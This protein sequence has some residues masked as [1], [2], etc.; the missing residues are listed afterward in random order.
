VISPRRDDGITLI[1]L[2]VSMMLLSVV[3]AVVVTAV[4]SASRSLRRNENEA[5]GLSD[6]R[7]VTERLGRDIEQARGVSAPGTLAPGETRAQACSNRLTLWIDYNSD[8]IQTVD[9]TVT[10]V[11]QGGSNGHFDVHRIVG[12]LAAPSSNVIEG[13]TLVSNVA[14]SYTPYDNA[15]DKCPVLPSS[16]NVPAP[17]STVSTSIKYNARAASGG[18]DK[19]IDF[20]NRLRNVL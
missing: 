18:S 14:F 10:W 6:V 4:V 8:Y 2:L 13:R 9:E 1:E 15:T 19:T 3:S 5:Q 12:S 11:L 17:T 20:T 7:V 16:T